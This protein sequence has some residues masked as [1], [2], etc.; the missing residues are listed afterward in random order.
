M[1]ILPFIAFIIIGVVSGFFG[2]LL[3]IS[4]GVITV[5]LL[6]GTLLLMDYPQAY[7]MHTALGTSLASMIFTAIGA[8][9]MQ[10]RHHNVLWE[11]VFKMLPGIIIGTL[12]GAA[13]AHFL[14]GILLEIIFGIFACILGANYLRPFIPRHPY[15]FLKHKKHFLIIG[16]FIGFVASILGIGG[17]IFLVPILF[18]LNFPEKKAFGTSAAAGIFVTF[19]ASLGFWLFGLADVNLGESLGYLYVPALL[20]IGIASLFTAPLG[21][22]Y[23]QR[24]SDGKLKKIFAIVLILV[25]IAMI[26]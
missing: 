16:L 6:L 12:V 18:A 2:G 11:P 17:G 4:G 20:I 8:S 22:H 15:D 25:G 21:V 23:M 7:A 14:S 24:I 1:E 19:F 10:N 26:F 9:W 5:P 13:V 3:G